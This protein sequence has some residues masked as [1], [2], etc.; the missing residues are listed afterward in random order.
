MIA[1]TLTVMLFLGQ[2]KSSERCT[3]RCNA[4]SSSCTSHC[5][6]SNKCMDNCARRSESCMS[7]CAL[8]VQGGDKPAKAKMP[9]KFDQV[10]HKVTPCTDEEVKQRGNA[11]KDAKH[12]LCRDAKGE[13]IACEGDE[14]KAK[15]L[16]KKYNVK[17]ECGEKNGVPIECPKQ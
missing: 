5:G 15:E 8:E 4:G 14:D 17:L 13:V 3:E 1:T 16:L 11:F 7:A 10:T 6:S 12:P 2:S 9:C